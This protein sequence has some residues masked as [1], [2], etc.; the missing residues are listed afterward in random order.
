[1]KLNEIYINNEDLFFATL[2]KYPFESSDSGSVFY[3]NEDCSSNIRIWHF[4]AITIINPNMHIRKLL[5]K[6]IKDNIIILDCPLEE[7]LDNLPN[8][9]DN[10]S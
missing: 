5:Q 6:L 2:R 1:M 7:F 4:G 3:S 10:R 8:I 9:C